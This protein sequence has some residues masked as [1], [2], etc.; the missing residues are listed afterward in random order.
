M[1]PEYEDLVV[2]VNYII[3]ERTDIHVRNESSGIFEWRS[4]K[5]HA[6][7]IVGYEESV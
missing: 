6:E 3:G 2:F 1:G 4:V 5:S 7:H